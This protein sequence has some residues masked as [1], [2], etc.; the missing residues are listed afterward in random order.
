M[1]NTFALLAALA[2]GLPLAASAGEVSPRA[3]TQPVPVQ[4]QAGPAKAVPLAAAQPGQVAQAGAATV[5]APETT[6]TG[7]APVTATLP[8][9]APTVA[10]PGGTGDQAREPRAGSDQVTGKRDDKV[11]QTK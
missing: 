8:P 5:K 6:K 9:A 3:G 1:K 4:Q 7:T 10:A 11:P 2:I